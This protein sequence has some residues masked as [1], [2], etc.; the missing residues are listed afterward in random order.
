MQKLSI[1]GNVGADAVVKDINGKKVIN[2]P[3]AVSESR[4]K[5]T[6]INCA[7]WVDAGG[8]V[9]VAKWLLKGTKVYAEGK[10]DVQTYVNKENKTAID[11]R[12]SVSFLELLGGAKKEDEKAAPT[13]ENAQDQFKDD[14]PF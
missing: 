6:W 1:I 11:F 4:E 14:L 7:R 5:T 9:E 2:F 8:S 13:A 3:V 12:L 10:P